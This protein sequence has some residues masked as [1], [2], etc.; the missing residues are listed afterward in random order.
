MYIINFTLIE[1]FAFSRFNIEVINVSNIIFYIKTIMTFVINILY[2]FS[3]F[4]M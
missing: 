3:S 2:Q 4:S 1:Y